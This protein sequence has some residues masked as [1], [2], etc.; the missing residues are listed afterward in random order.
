MQ[1]VGSA[2]V[3]AVFE[4]VRAQY[5]NG[6][7]SSGISLDASATGRT[8]N[9][10]ATDTVSSDNGSGNDGGGFRIEGNQSNT[11]N[12]TVVRSVAANNHTGVLGDT[13]GFPS[14]AFISQTTITNG[15]FACNGVVESYQDNTIHNNEVDVCDARIISKE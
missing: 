15:V 5:N 10:T 4:R 1:P 13:E 12:L 14:T 7:A 3:T 9:G 6:R 2:S 11:N 8:I